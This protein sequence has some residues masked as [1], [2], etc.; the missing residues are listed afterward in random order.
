MQ[1]LIVSILLYF[2]VLPMLGGAIAFLTGG[3]RTGL[4]RKG[5]YADYHPLNPFYRFGPYHFGRRR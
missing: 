4:G 1:T 5:A 3:I 2:L